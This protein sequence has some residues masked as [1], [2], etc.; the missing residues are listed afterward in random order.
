MFIIFYKLVVGW[1]MPPGCFILL[2]MVCAWKTRSI[3]DPALRKTL[4]ALAL[5]GAVGLYLLSIQPVLHL[6]ASGLENIYPVVQE[7]Q[8]KKTNAIVVLSAGIV[9]GVP[10]SFSSFLAAPSPS[11]IV[12]LSEGIRLYR[13]IKAEERVC[14]IILTGGRFYGGLYAASVV[15]REWL[16]SM[17]IPASDIHLETSSRTTFEE[18]RFVLPT[19]RNVSAEAV[20]LV[21]AASHMPRAVATFNTFGLSVI[22]APCDFS[23]SAKLGLFSFLP[24]AA[25]LRENRLLLWEYL[26]AVYYKVRRK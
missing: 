23:G 26:G 19:V 24:E 13:R 7:A 4:R 15:S 12:R 21:T 10:A 11:A 2:F 25:A 1:L 9:E 17:G 16:I 6:L 5:V 3:T 18:A 20:F 8:I 14:T 22:P